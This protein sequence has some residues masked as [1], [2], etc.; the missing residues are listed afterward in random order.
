MGLDMYLKAERYLYYNPDLVASDADYAERYKR[1]KEQVEAVAKI[2]G[3]EPLGEGEGGCQIQ[4]P[5][6]YWRK[7]NA[8]HGWFVQNVQGG[9]DDCGPYEVGW[10]ELAELRETCKHILDGWG[11][12]TEPRPEVV[13]LIE[14]TLPPTEGFFFG[15]YEIDQWYRQD[16]VNTVNQI[17]AIEGAYPEK[18]TRPWFIY[19]SSW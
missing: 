3:L 15:S 9:K 14:S 17:D 1:G 18:D 6:A 5:V 12:D 7:A 19:Q 8:I 16:L 11:E 10:T 4:V 2:V 13:E